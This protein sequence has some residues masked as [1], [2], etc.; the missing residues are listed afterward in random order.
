MTS[1]YLLAIVSVQLSW[2]VEDRSFNFLDLPKNAMQR[3]GCFP[4]P[5]MK[6]SCET[7]LLLSRGP[8]SLE[9]LQIGQ[10]L[11]CSFDHG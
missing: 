2:V 11:L 10:L 4:V 9:L 5:V 3:G 6:S 7:R 8:I 1:D